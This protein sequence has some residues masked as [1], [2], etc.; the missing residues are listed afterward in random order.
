MRGTTWEQLAPRICK[1]EPFVNVGGGLIT[2]LIT[3]IYIILS[4]WC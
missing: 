1:D 4:K 2:G 3:A